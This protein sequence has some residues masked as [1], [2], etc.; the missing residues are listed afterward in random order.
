MM[1]FQSFFP[2]FQVVFYLIFLSF[3]PRTY[4]VKNPAHNKLMESFIRCVPLFNILHGVFHR[5]IY[6]VIISF[7]SF[8]FFEN[9]TVRITSYTSRSIKLNQQILFFFFFMAHLAKCCILWEFCNNNTSQWSQWCTTHFLPRC[10]FRAQTGPPEP[11]PRPPESPELLSA[12]L[13][14]AKKTKQQQPSVKLAGF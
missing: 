2:F 11:D 6:F 13:F 4:L 3:S 8:F 14:L 9:N 12:F 7:P 1:L 5:F 10:R